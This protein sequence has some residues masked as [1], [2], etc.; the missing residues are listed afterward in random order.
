LAKKL[1]VDPVTIIKACQSIG[2]KGFHELKKR[3]KHNI[4]SL[5]PGTP[6][7]KFLSEFEINTS[8]EEAIRN[9]LSRDVQMLNGTIE[10]VSFENI[11]RTS[12]CIVG[13]AQ[14]YVIGL[15][16]I[17]AIAQYL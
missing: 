14:T 12:E 8:A 17:G 7:D 6:I 1:Q 11:I 16:Y 5:G 10:K 9:A 2:L 15:G 13:S 3:L 4:K